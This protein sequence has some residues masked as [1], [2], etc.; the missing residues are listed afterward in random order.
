MGSV[1]NVIFVGDLWY[2]GVREEY[3]EDMLE[4]LF[5]V[6]DVADFAGVLV[7]ASKVFQARW[8]GIDGRYLRASQ[9]PKIDPAIAFRYLNKQCCLQGGA[10]SVDG[11]ND[12][13]AIIHGCIQAWHFAPS[14][15]F[16]DLR[17]E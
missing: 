12:G 3:V 10:A 8:R 13:V 9:T 15:E 5:V 17:K 11:E 7:G 16:Y 14:F 4:C 2:L 1:V 6:F